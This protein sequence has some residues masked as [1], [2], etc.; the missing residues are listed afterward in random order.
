MKRWLMDDASLGQPQL[1]LDTE[2]GEDL[3]TAQRAATR[4]LTARGWDGQVTANHSTVRVLVF[5]P[6]RP[7]RAELAALAIE[8]ENSVGEEFAFSVDRSMH[9][10]AFRRDNLNDSWGIR[11]WGRR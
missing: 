10:Q 2:H 9:V 7:T 6:V 4:A 8:I 3:F 1:A 5:K 11:N